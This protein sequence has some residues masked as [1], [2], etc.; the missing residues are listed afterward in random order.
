MFT[1]HEISQMERE[2]CDF[3]VNVR[4]PYPTYSMHMVS[5]CAAKAAAPTSATPAPNSTTS[6]IPASGEQHQATPTKAASYLPPP[7]L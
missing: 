5:K 4:A 6:P 7:S 3:A 1:L 2:M